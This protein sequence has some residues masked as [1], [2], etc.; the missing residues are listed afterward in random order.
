MS[1]INIRKWSVIVLT[2][3]LTIIL[4]IGVFLSMTPQKKASASSETVTVT[5]AIDTDKFVPGDT[6]TITMAIHSTYTDAASFWSGGDIGV[7][8]LKSDGAGGYL[9]EFDK[10][11][12]ACFESDPYTEG[13]YEI[14]GLNTRYSYDSVLDKFATDGYYNFGFAYK[15]SGPKVLP[16]VDLTVKIHITV[17]SLPAA[18]IVTF[19]TP[20]LSKFKIGF[21]AAQDPMASRKPNTSSLDIITCNTVSVGS[22]PAST[23]ATLSALKVGHGTASTNLTIADTMSAESDSES[24]NNYKVNPTTTDPNTT[25]K[26]ATTEAGLASATAIKSG[27]TATVTLDGTVSQPKVFIEVTAQ[28]GTTK[29]RYTVNVTI[30]YVALA[31]LAVT[32]DSATRPTK[33]G[34]AT[35]FN[36]A[37][38]AYTVNVPS[39]ATK[40]TVGVRIPG[41]FGINPTLALAATG[42]TAPASI[43]A[44][45]NASFDVTGIDT[46]DKLVITA[47]AKDGVTRKAYTLTFQRVSVDTSITSIYATGAKTNQRIEYDPAQSNP[48]GTGSAINYSFQTTY[49]DDYQAKL[50][51]TVATGATIRIDNNAY[52]AAANRTAPY[53]G[54]VR[55]TAEA[56]NTRDYKVA[57]TK[58][59]PNAELK[60][61]EFS[62]DGGT[63]WEDVLSSADFASNTF[64]K[65]LNV[66]D[67]AVGGR[68]QFRATPSAASTVVA[69]SNLT[70]GNNNVYVG[71]LAF[72]NNH[73]TLAARNSEGINTY[74]FDIT[75]V[76]DLNTIESVTIQ[77]G[78][79]AL[80]G[81]TWD[82][83]TTSYT[84]N[85]PYSVTSLDF[86]AVTDGS[87]TQVKSGTNT[88]DRNQTIKTH[89]RTEQLSVGANTITLTPTANNGTGA[90]GTAYTFVIT[91]AEA[92]S[93]NKLSDLVVTING[94]KKEINFDPDTGTY[95]I[96]DDSNSLVVDI[97]AT[98]NDPTATVTGAGTHD[99]STGWQEGKNQVITV[100]V[101]A[102]NGEKKDYQI[103]I[104]KNEIKLDEN[105]DISSITVTGSDGVQ[106]FKDYLASTHE[107]SFTVPYKVD[108]VNVAAKAASGVAKITGDGN[109]AL[110]VGENVIEVYATAESGA[111]GDGAVKYVFTITREAAKENA[112]LTSISINNRSVSGFDKTVFDYTDRQDSIVN[113]I[114]LSAVA[115]DTDATVTIQIGDKVVNA[116]TGHATGL[117]PLGEPGSVTT[118]TVKVTIDDTTTIYTVRVV[119]SSNSP[120]LTYINVG[121]DPGYPIYDYT[122]S[123]GGVHYD[124]DVID[125][126]DEVVV[127][128]THYYHVYL[129]Y[130]LTSVLISA[131]ADDPTAEIRYDDVTSTTSGEIKSTTLSTETLFKN[132]RLAVIQI[133][134]VPTIGRVGVYYLY[135]TR[136]LALSSNTDLKITI[137]QVTQGGG[138]ATP[139]TGFNE[140]FTENP[141]GN[142]FGTYY[143]DYRMSSLN[144]TIVPTPPNA[145]TAPATVSSVVMRL[146]DSENDPTAVDLTGAEEN[147]Y[148]AK[149]SYERTNV[150]LVNVTSSDGTVTR[151]IVILVDRKLP[152]LESLAVK[153]NEEVA[154]DFAPEKEGY[155]FSVANNVEKLT[156]DAKVA[157]ADG[158]RVV[159]EDKALQIGANEIRI[160]IYENT[161]AASPQSVANMAF[162]PLADE[163]G[164]LVRTITL[165]V[166]R[167]AK[168]FNL[169]WIIL[170]F[171][172]LV[173]AI[174]EFIII[175][176]TL[177]HRNKQE[178]RPVVRQ[179][180]VQQQP[181]IIMAPPAPRQAPVKKKKKTQPVNVEVH[182]T[183]MG[184]QDGVYNSDGSKKG[185]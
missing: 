56:G 136:E 106:Y 42:C 5:Y 95:A 71:E 144:M 4:G 6:F 84:L 19:G 34:L 172:L 129:P 59:V 46:G 47:T 167:E 165:N 133:S 149:L 179:M 101:I 28:D 139:L 85:V 103:I 74:S 75:L 137:D 171:I 22:A 25:I 38:L 126:E 43:E 163:G 130:E 76:E 142:I 174:I 181:T 135:L 26:I 54:T 127:G 140:K 114:D 81:F 63:T 15:G 33:N 156:V 117:I 51:I 67:I 158:L 83:A 91:R 68:V 185:D 164:K 166:N 77:N 152:A 97:E 69:S 23:D 141:K 132:G 184:D 1:R 37:T 10:E 70:A 116:G 162:A 138:T 96:Q 40:A 65:K 88:L 121:G 92:S 159:V 107:Y 80:S 86:A 131:S 112:F 173:I 120:L 183:G 109:H 145:D 82:K 151:T 155:M 98:P 182:I 21:G 160:Y 73:F 35:A 72:G 39:D 89:T 58:Y 170:F 175:L 9:D 148:V 122:D 50:V 94:E 180:P 14:A 113:S 64:T 161:S 104:S 125:N 53:T 62:S 147:L 48:T 17:K 11:I 177:L 57:L 78:G 41:G 87:Y 52:N 150:I 99:L 154:D 16:T 29:K 79:T 128:A 55:V 20:A 100:S 60:P 143:L 45:S 119:K 31:N 30:K 49:E 111:N 2:V 90:A 153:E 176:Y 66:K 146:S 118:V 124:G 134:V 8:P 27:A 169:I 44:S 36:K 178:E 108:N 32:T 93:D 24:L 105:F 12:A 18:S 157:E 123:V 13:T 110:E 7:G 115:E 61:L 3:L 168:D 102:E